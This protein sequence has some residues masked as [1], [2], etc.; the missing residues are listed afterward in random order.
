MTDTEVLD[1]LLATI[2]NAR[3]PSPVTRENIA[4]VIDNVLKSNIGLDQQLRLAIDM[5]T[6]AVTLLKLRGG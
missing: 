5:S 6:N 3:P 4:D 2:N 1:T